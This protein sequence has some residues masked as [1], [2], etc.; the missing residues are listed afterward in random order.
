MKVHLWSNAWGST[1]LRLMSSF[2]YSLMLIGSCA[3]K[4]L[5]L[6]ITSISFMTFQTWGGL[7]IGLLPMNFKASHRCSYEKITTNG[8]QPCR[9]GSMF[10]SFSCGQFLTCN[11]IFSWNLPRFT[12]ICFCMQGHFLC[13]GKVLQPWQ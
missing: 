13:V 11:Q 4:P 7:K 12:P 8:K 1:T 9:V 3:F 6:K 5:G 10:N 2:L